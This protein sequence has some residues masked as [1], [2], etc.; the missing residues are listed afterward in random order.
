MILN[1][2]KGSIKMITNKTSQL[3]EGFRARPGLALASQMSGLPGLG[4]ALPITGK[5]A[6]GLDMVARPGP[7]LVYRCQAICLV[8]QDWARLGPVLVK[9]PTFRIWFARSGPGLASISKPDVW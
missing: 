7:D 4:Q 5:H 9:M 8:C 6:H 1:A 3:A 2:L